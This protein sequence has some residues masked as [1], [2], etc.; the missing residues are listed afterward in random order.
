MPLPPPPPLLRRA[1]PSNENSDSA[2][3]DIEEINRENAVTVHPH[4]HHHGPEPRPTDILD[5]NHRLHQISQDE[6]R[7]HSVEISRFF[8]HSNFS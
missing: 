5:M 6:V 4:R 8:S 2:D 3:E 1:T 7:F